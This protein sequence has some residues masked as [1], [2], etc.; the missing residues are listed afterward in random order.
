V[1]VLVSKEFLVLVGLAFLIAVP[2]TWWAMSQWLHEFAYRTAVSWWIFPL[3]GA[4]ALAIAIL[5]ISYQAAR[6]A[7]ANPIKSLHN[8]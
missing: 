5:T 4:S 8:E 2:V 3:A 6:A 1:L 7:T